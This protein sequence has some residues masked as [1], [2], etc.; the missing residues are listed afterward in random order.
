MWIRNPDQKKTL[1]FWTVICTVY[2]APTILNP[3]YR[4]RYNDESN[5]L[6]KKHD[7]KERLTPLPV[8]FAAKLQNHEIL[9]CAR[10]HANW[11]A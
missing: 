5:S 10:P 4:Y 7:E 9:P 8:K 1:R 6:W 2:N 3:V 11:Q